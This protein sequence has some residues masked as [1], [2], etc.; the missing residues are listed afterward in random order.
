[1][2][3]TSPYIAGNILPC[4]RSQLLLKL[5]HYQLML[6]QLLGHQNLTLP[7]LSLLVL[8]LFLLAQAFVV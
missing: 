6:L 1:M 5:L 8:L 7:F 3:G 4:K 2:L